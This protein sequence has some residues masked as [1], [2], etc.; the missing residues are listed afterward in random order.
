MISLGLTS[1]TFR[2]LS[3]EEIINLAK[4][5][6]IYNIEWGG[7]VHVKNED[8]ASYIYELCIKNNIKCCSFGSY[9][10]AGTYNGEYMDEFIKILNISLKL[11]CDTIRI[12]AYDKSSFDIKKDSYEYNTI[13]EEIRKI[14]DYADSYK[15]SISF[16]HHQRTLTDD[17]DN[18]LMFIKDIGRK[19]VHMYWQAQV[20]LSF[21][22]NIQTLNRFKPYLKNLH[23]SNQVQN[24]YLLL[25][26]MK[27]QLEQYLDIVKNH[28]I[29]ALIE[30]VKDNKIESY[31]EDVDVLKKIL[32][33]KNG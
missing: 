3:V 14:A 31:I 33:N 5:T 8:D 32:A 24:G 2:K 20:S 17:T 16:E 23:I 18:A 13:I 6:G 4:N 21:E 1:V 22:E 30:F 19:N 15:M 27:E 25:Y 26:D 7:D 29:I 10:K 28:E 12:W 11:H 9:Y